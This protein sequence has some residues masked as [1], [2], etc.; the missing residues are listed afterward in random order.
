MRQQQQQQQHC[1]VYFVFGSEF[2]QKKYFSKILQLIFIYNNSFLNIIYYFE[3]NI[4]F[5]QQ[6]KK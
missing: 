6:I 5:L 4:T 3:N 2:E 1:T